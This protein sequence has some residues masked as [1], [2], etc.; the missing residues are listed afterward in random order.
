[1]DARPGRAFVRAR[2]GHGRRDRVEPL[3]VQL[4]QEQC[5]G[6]HWKP[7]E[8]IAERTRSLASL[9]AASASPTTARLGSPRGKMH[10]DGD[11]WGLHA[12]LGAAI[13]GGEHGIL[14]GR[15]RLTSVGQ[16]RAVRNPQFPVRVASFA[17][18]GEGVG[19][20]SSVGFVH[21]GR[22][23]TLSVKNAPVPSAAKL[24]RPAEARAAALV[25]GLSG[26]APGHTR[27][28]CR[29]RA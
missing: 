26:S 6:G 16:H 10:V 22:D 5:P 25:P 3:A 29:S 14:A 12:E 23:I 27:C 24:R 15:Q 11:G 1:M 18:V 9:T 4:P 7:E 13:D 28:S 2:I 8:V 17:C 21:P 20:L 19:K